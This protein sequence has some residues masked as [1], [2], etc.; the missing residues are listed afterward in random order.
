MVIVIF[1]QDSLIP[2]MVHRI[3][4]NGRK[5]L[6]YKECFDERETRNLKDKDK[7]DRYRQKKIAREQEDDVQKGHTGPTCCQVLRPSKW[8]AQRRRQEGHNYMLLEE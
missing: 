6:K 7:S 2:R 5:D 3:K 8:Q 4:C 1:K